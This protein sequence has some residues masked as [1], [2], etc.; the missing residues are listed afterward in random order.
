MY[1][2]VYIFLILMIIWRNCCHV[3][4]NINY[5][6][7]Y[8]LNGEV[9]YRIKQWGSQLVIGHFDWSLPKTELVKKFLKALC[10]K[11]CMISAST[12]QRQPLLTLYSLV[13]HGEN[14]GICVPYIH[15]IPIQAHSWVWQHG[16]RVYHRL[17]WYST[18]DTCGFL[19]SWQVHL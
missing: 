10:E 14:R 15:H 13:F 9:F 16:Q 4:G 5:N 12:K 2:H 3:Y 17:Q 11:K 1:I 6:F 18:V 7:E 19:W 8:F